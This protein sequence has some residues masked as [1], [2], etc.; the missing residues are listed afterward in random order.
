[1]RSYCEIIKELSGKVKNDNL[2]DI[3]RADANN[4]I[5]QLISLLVVYD[6]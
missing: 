2:T 6:I 1:M 3:D 5:N 4:L